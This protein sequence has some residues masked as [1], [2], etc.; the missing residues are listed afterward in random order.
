MSNYYKIGPVASTD[1]ALYLGF[2]CV[3]TAS[4]NVT[5]LR[6]MGTT[7][8]HQVTAGKSLY[9]VKIDLPLGAPSGSFGFLGYADNDVGLDT[10]TARVTPVSILGDPE[11]A[12]GG[13]A[14]GAMTGTPQNPNGLFGPIPATKYPY[15]RVTLGMV[16]AVNLIVWGIER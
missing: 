12:L 16:G 4:G 15:F 6:K 7:V 9:I 8:G 11:A 10:A 13:F 2:W 14:V 1:P 5:H 3:V